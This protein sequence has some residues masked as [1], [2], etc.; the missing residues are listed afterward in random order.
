MHDG[1]IMFRQ[2]KRG[3]I[4]ELDFDLWKIDFDITSKCSYQLLQ[5]YEKYLDDNREGFGKTKIMYSGRFKTIIML[6]VLSKD[7]DDWIDK[8]IEILREKKNLEKIDIFGKY[9]GK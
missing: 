5:E 2:R 1:Y 3:K 4:V 6:M 9:L 7:A 8:I